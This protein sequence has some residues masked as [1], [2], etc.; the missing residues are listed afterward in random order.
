MHAP[1]KIQIEIVCI[2]A[3]MPMWDY[4]IYHIKYCPLVIYLVPV[5]YLLL[6][7]LNTTEPNAPFSISNLDF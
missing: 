1:W 5:S 4:G 2:Q 3:D 7:M 6:V